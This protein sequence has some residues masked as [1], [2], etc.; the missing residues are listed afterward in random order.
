[1]T[2]RKIRMTEAAAA[3]FDAPLDNTA[4]RFGIRQAERYREEL[5]AGIEKIADEPDKIKTAFRNELAEGTDYSLYL[6]GGRYIAYQVYGKDTVIIAGI[7]RGDMEVPRY[8]R[9]LQQLNAREIEAI[10]RIIAKP[11]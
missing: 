9:E 1:M 10:R 3:A 11:I 2:I 4:S 5:L 6:V 8:L 7:F